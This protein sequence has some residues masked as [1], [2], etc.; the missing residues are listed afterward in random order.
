MEEIAMFTREDEL[1]K[2]YGFAC[3]F[4]HMDTVF[5]GSKPDIVWSSIHSQ[6]P[7]PLQPYLENL[8][9]NLPLAPLDAETKILIHSTPFQMKFIS[10]NLFDTGSYYGSV[11][12]GPFLLEELSAAE[13]N[14][15]IFTNQLPI[16]LLPMLEQ[17]YQSLP[18]I[19]KEKAQRIAEFLAYLASHFDEENTGRFEHVTTYNIQNQHV[20]LPETIKHKATEEALALIEKR[21]L[22]EN[23]LMAAIETGN[24]EKLSVV[25]KEINLIVSNLPDR[26]ANNPLRSRKNLAFVTNTLLRKSAEKGG[27]HPLYIDSI[28][29]KFAI[30]IEKTSSIQQLMD[31][32]KKMYM[33]YC[34]AVRRLSLSNWSPLI[35]STIEYIRLH[36]DQELRLEVIARA[37]HTSSYELSRQF[38]KETGQSITAY[39]NKQRIHEAVQL[40][41]NESMSITDIAQ[42]V[43]F[44]DVNYFTKVFKQFQG[45]TPSKFRQI[46]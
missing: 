37:V 41:Q 36:I 17:Y 42:M 39:I 33:E 23:K 2:I 9:E 43:G 3:E 21:Y 25:E 29:E 4:S 5:T 28:S 12:V 34:D 7:G 13:L 15:I 40:L 14:E 26:I 35:K 16:W 10:M 32:H 31:L 44:S 22:T 27:V 1:K 11:S 30:Q 45:C 8:R 20:I 38:N 6:I 46:E 18:L 24:L 19:S